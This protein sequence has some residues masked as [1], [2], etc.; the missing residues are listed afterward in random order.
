MIM[1]H[2]MLQSL[3]H[4]LKRIMKVTGFSH[5]CER[6]LRHLEYIEEQNARCNVNGKILGQINEILY[7]DLFII[8]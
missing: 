3:R 8:I 6:Y 7:L 4:D 5:H 2:Q 1:V